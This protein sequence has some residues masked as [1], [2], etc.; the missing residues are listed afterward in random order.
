MIV[1]VK[2]TISP[3]S[4][5]CGS[6]AMLSTGSA[7]RVFWVVGGTLVDETLVGVTVGELV[8]V[9]VT[10]GVPDCIAVDCTAVCVAVCVTI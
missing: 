4:A 6:A 9:A 5:S 8:L 7:A 2:V 10:K 3:G 1:I